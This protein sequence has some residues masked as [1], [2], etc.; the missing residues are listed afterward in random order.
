MAGFSYGGGGAGGA[1]VLPIA[2]GSNFLEVDWMSDTLGPAALQ[3]IPLLKDQ[4]VLLKC[5]FA[6][7]GDALVTAAAACPR[8]VRLWL[9]HTAITGANLAELRTLGNLKYLNLTGTGIGA[10]DVAKLKGAPKLAELYLYQTKVGR[11][12]WA[13]LQRDFPRVSMDTGGYAI[14]FLTTD[15]AIVR[16]PVKK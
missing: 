12:D 4:L 15:T 2:Q 1:L 6:R 16:E 11:A 10:S 14:P 5:S 7:E 9:D 8:L 3:A 13:A